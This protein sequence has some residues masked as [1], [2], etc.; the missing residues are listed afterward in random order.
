MKKILAYYCLAF[1]YM[2]PLS[3]GPAR[4]QMPDL[5][6]VYAI[7][8]SSSDD[9]ESAIDRG[10]ESMNFLIQGLA[11]SR[12]A[13]T[14]P[15]Y[16]RIEISRTDTTVSVQFDSR[17]PIV[18]PLDGRSVSWIRED[19]GRDDVSAQWSATQ[20]VMDFNAGSD[21]ERINTLVLGPDGNELKLNVKL[22]STHL[23]VPI[24][25]ALVYRRQVSP[26]SETRMK[27][28]AILAPV[29]GT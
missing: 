29:R 25:Y 17:E 12:I 6:G 20:L 5:R 2:L 3:A 23:P 14:S 1:T 16:E 7:D 8:I 26:S 19:G 21:G 15:R 18:I 24:T 9:I 13:Q 11:R 4:A 27:N 10:T 28:G 22:L